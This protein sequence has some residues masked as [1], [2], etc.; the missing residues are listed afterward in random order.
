VFR[1]PDDFAAFERILS[2]GC[3]LVD[4]RVLAWCLMPD[5]FHLV[6]WPR[7]KGSIS[8]FMQW[9]TTCHVRRYH[10]QHRSS[11]HV[12]QGRFKAFVA[13]NGAHLLSV[14]RYVEYNPVR[15]GL[16]TR[17]EDW[18]WGSARYASESG[19]FSAGSI[20]EK[21]PDP[22]SA[23][24]PGEIAP[25]LPLS[26]YLTAGP[27]RRPKPWLG[28]VN[29][30]EDAAEL[31]RLRAAVHRGTPFGQPAWQQKMAAKLGLESTLRPRGRPRKK[32]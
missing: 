24:N 5:H 27:V 17:A 8:R 3:E 28:F 14:L 6:L 18:P 26:A 11:G 4:M 15:A 9:V 30:P 22:V 20:A 31:Q 7:K 1:K 21:V 13:Q 2:L 10:R 23:L 32:A 29:Q 12:W 19:S 25:R 16:A